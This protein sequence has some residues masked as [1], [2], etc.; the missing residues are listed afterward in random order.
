MTADIAASPEWDALRRHHDEIAGK[1]LREFFAED[2]DRGRELAL[3][4]GDLYIDYSK[5]R[6]T[7][8]T[9]SL[10]VD[11]AKAKGIR[12]IV[13]QKGFDAKGARAIARD[14]GGRLVEAD[15]LEKDWPSGLR[16]FTKT[17]TRILRP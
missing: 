12:D 6:I 3:T 1:H 4:V 17:L 7:R 5:H 11:L 10:L 16:Q 13:T 2:P 14:I 9:L 15:P 8:E